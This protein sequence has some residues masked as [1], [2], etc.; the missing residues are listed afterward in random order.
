MGPASAKLDSEVMPEQID[1]NGA[2]RNPMQQVPGKIGI[3]FEETHNGCKKD[4]FPWFHKRT[5]EGFSQ[6][7]PHMDH[8]SIQASTQKRRWNPEDGIIENPSAYREG[9]G[10]NSSNWNPDVQTDVENIENVFQVTGLPSD[11]Q[12]SGGQADGLA[13]CIAIFAQTWTGPRVSHCVPKRNQMEPILLSELGATEQ[14]MVEKQLV[15][16]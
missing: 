8:K 11:L 12:S 1:N 7:K 6:V 9:M 10:S 14:I 15:I 5:S 16:P 4:I 13:S 2:A 3:E